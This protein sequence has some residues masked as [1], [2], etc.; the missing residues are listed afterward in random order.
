MSIDE[1]L[2]WAYR[3]V[4]KIEQNKKEEEEGISGF[5][6]SNVDPTRVF[7]PK[8]QTRPW[9]KHFIFEKYKISLKNDFEGGNLKWC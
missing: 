1:K 4:A 9:F 3:N 2:K 6:N 8:E 7:Q 5:A